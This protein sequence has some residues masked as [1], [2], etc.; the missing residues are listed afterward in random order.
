MSRTF[1]QPQA[2]AITTDAEG[3]PAWLRWRGRRERV[4]V[5]NAWRVEGAWWRGQPAGRAYYTLLTASRVALV[6][7]HDEASPPEVGW[8]LERILD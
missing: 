8:Q 7:Y 1:Q 6:V 2:L 4:S 5:C 3:R